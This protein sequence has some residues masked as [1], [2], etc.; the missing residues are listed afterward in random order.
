MHVS[1]LNRYRKLSAKTFPSPSSLPAL[2]S[3]LACSS[4]SRK[5]RSTDRKFY[6][7]SQLNAKQQKL[8][9]APRSTSSGIVNSCGIGNKANGYEVELFHVSRS[10]HTCDVEW[11]IFNLNFSESRERFSA[12]NVAIFVSFFPPLLGIL[13]VLR[14]CFAATE[15]KRLRGDELRDAPGSWRLSLLRPHLTAKPASSRSVSSLSFSCRRYEWH[16]KRQHRICSKFHNFT[17]NFRK[18]VII[19]TIPPRSHPH[20]VHLVRVD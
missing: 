6:F 5:S 8:P 18:T 17:R 4:G 2:H 1:P 3:Q 10:L 13:R 19:V 9:P 14:V 11:I 12:R 7:P 15:P 20:Q 16:S